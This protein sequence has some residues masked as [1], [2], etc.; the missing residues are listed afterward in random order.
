MRAGSILFQKIAG[1]IIK[2]TDLTNRNT[3]YR[4]ISF[5]FGVQTLQTR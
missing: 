1:T 2:G 4:T 5:H 3:Y